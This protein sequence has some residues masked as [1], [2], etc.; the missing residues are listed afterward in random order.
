MKKQYIRISIASFFFAALIFG[1]SCSKKSSDPTP[2]TLTPTPP[3]ATSTKPA[4][5]NTA[6]RETVPPEN[7]TG[8]PPVTEIPVGSVVVQDQDN[9]R[10]EIKDQGNKDKLDNLTGRGTSQGRFESD[11]VRTDFGWIVADMT[12]DG[13]SYTDQKIFDD[14]LQSIFFF[15]I[16]SS[17]YYWQFKTKTKKWFWGTYGI[18]TGMTSIAFDFNSKLLPKKVW[19]ISKI[20]QDRL[21]ISGSFDIDN[22]GNDN[23]VVIGFNAYDLTNSNFSG[24]T[25]PVLGQEKFVGNWVRYSRDIDPANNVSY[26]PS[27]DKLFVN[28]DGTYESISTI[29][30]QIYTDDGSWLL[31]SVTD[32]TST[33]YYFYPTYY[34]AELSVIKTDE[35]VLSIDGAFMVMVKVPDSSNPNSETLYFGRP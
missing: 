11:P 24:E 4:A 16:D 21:V 25:E 34:D 32:K 35:Y 19:I 26:T 7:G 30:G 17:G 1:M 13:K 12:I 3:V 20:T 5:P 28:V 33:N 9:Q 23:R 14:T 22:D 31:E 8:R 18:D 2:A 27:D 29:N 15:N 10:A 6:K